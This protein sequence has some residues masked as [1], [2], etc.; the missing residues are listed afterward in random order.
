MYLRFFFQVALTVGLER[1][2]KAA[3]EGL[4]P[5]TEVLWASAKHGNWKGLRG[6][7]TLATLAGLQLK[8]QK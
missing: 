2:F 3:S 4:V 1:Y 6:R 7:K 8:R 5:W